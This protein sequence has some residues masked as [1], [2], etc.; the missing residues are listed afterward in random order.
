MKLRLKKKNAIIATV[1]LVVILIEFINPFENSALNS[2]KELNYSK[3]SS[4][5]IVEYGLKN[6]VLDDGYNKFVDKNIKDNDFIV[7][8]YE[9]YKNLNYYEDTN[10]VSLVNKLIE[11]GYNSESINCILGSGT[12]DSIKEFL[13]RDK[14]DEN[15]I[16][17]FLNFNFS[18]LDNLDKYIEYRELN[19]CTDD[20]AVVYVN[21]G[22]DREFYTDYDNV[23]SFSF[24][25][26][27]NKYNKLSDDF[28]PVDLIS[29]PSKYCSGECEKGNKTMIDAFVTMAE[30]L[31]TETGLNIYANSAYRSFSEQEKTYNTYL[32]LYGE[33]YVYNY[34]SY[35]GFSEHQ[36]GLCV[37][38]KAG[39]KNTFAGTDESKWL[40]NNA[41]KYGFILRYTS[42]NQEITGYRSEEWHY[43]YVGIE[44]AKY[45]KENNITLEEYSIRYGNKGE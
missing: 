21:L 5:L 34:V 22:L 1:I 43:R 15:V 41:Y 35:P 7:A 27:V 4:K 37:D 39:S 31:N 24:T 44:A 12:I 6:D 20:E 36:T 11:K 14:V 33:K 2:L 45:I 26:V 38:I 8:N 29:F 3:Q 17:Q 32:D 19:V 9:I 40:K 13:E 30:A 28:V 25:M 42:A 18:I 10:S 16:K 23:D